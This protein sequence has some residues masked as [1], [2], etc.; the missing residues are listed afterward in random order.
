M[1]GHVDKYSLSDR[2]RVALSRS[3]RA[4]A[5]SAARVGFAVHGSPAVGNECLAVGIPGSP[6]G[7]LSCCGAKDILVEEVREFTRADGT[8]V[9]IRCASSAVVEMTDAPVHVHAETLEYYVILAGAGR[10]VLGAGDQERIVSVGEGSVILLPPGQ[11]HGI[12]SEDPEVPVKALL[13]FYPG[14]APV[15]EPEFR[16]E[17]ILYARTS[18]RIEALERTLGKT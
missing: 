15:T 18:K 5:R 7:E 6:A 8:S 1:M 3:L 4:R 9:Q 12:V 17:A 16:D 10:M 13:T 14:L 11:A 2:E